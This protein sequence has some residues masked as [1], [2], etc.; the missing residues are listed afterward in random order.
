MHCNQ[1]NFVSSSLTWG[2]TLLSHTDG[3]LYV[4]YC[5]IG[6]LGQISDGVEV[7]LHLVNVPVCIRN[8]TLH[9][10]GHAACCWT[11]CSLKDNNLPSKIKY[12]KMFSLFLLIRHLQNYHFG[13]TSWCCL[14][15]F[16]A[17]LRKKNLDQILCD[18]SSFKRIVKNKN[19]PPHRRREGEEQQESCRCKKWWSHVPLCRQQWSCPLGV[20]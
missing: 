7:L 20:E 18:R 16:A 15:W 11:V 10:I 6:S 5:F 13:C 19:C 12:A 8:I 4:L 3:I 9:V 17:K 2:G 1:T 14:L